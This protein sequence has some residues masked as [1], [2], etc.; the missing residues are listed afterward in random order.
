MRTKKELGVYLSHLKVF[1]NPKWKLEQ[2]P[3]DSEIAADIIWHA[4]IVGD[5]KDKII[6]D[7]GCGTGI[8][9][10]GALI[11]GAKKVYFIDIDSSAINIA[12]ENLKKVEEEYVV[13]EYEF[14]NSNIEDLE[15]SADIVLQN[16]PFGVKDDHA[17]R[18]FLLKAFKTGKVIYSFHKLESKGFINALSED[19]G[20]EVTNLFEFDFPLK[21]TMDYNKKKIQRIRV[22]CWRLQK[23]NI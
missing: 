4:N 3:T 21:Q 12:K 6:A 9:G 8:L 23:I 11:A 19:E 16:P 20:F 5:F 10:I 13:G 1:E 7:L 18:R 2:Y 17:D 22:G 14:I 15:L